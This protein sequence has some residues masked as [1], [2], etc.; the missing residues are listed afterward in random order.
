M[1]SRAAA[2]LERR[3]ELIQ[4]A[5]HS[6]CSIE[7]R[8][9]QENEGVRPLCAAETMRWRP[10]GHRDVVK[11]VGHAECTYLR[12]SVEPKTRLVTRLR[13]FPRPE[14]ARPC[15]GARVRPAA[16]DSF[17]NSCRAGQLREPTRM[18]GVIDQ[19]LQAP[20]PGGHALTTHHVHVLR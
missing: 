15:L 4:R 13:Q 2:W 5:R 14:Q 20:V 7:H 11:C 3:S 9:D 1:I 17:R 8:D 16:H 6:R 10:T 19:L 18:S 12:Q